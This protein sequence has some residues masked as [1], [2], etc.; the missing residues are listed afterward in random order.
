MRPFVRISL[1]ML[2]LIA[3]MTPAKAGRGRLTVSLGRSP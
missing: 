2:L 1:L 3:G